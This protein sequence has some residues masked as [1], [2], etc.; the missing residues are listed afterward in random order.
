MT[1]RL[2][3]GSTLLL[4]CGVSLSLRKRGFPGHGSDGLVWVAKDCARRSG[5]GGNCTSWMSFF[6]SWTT[7]ILLILHVRNLYLGFCI[8]FRCLLS[9]K[10]AILTSCPF[11]PLWETH[12]QSCYH[13]WHLDP[14]DRCPDR[15]LLSQCHLEIDHLRFP[16]RWALFP[17]V[18][19]E[20]V[21]IRS[22]A[23]LSLSYCLREPGSIVWMAKEPVGRL[24]LSRRL[25]SP[26]RMW[27]D[28]CQK[29]SPSENRNILSSH[30]RGWIF[31]KG[32]D[33]T[34]YGW[35]TAFG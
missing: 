31:Q 9:S 34:P 23:H 6:Q 29:R 35:H 16:N 1:P 27:L 26:R 14:F 33:G 3:R 21:P 2:S 18:F 11:H 17:T 28:K 30:L 22:L 32:G 20:L 7:W 8:S 15:S 19:L 13:R 10:G 12:D 25:A 4:V 24:T 5:S